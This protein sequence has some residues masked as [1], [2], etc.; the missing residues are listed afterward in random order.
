MI[1]V[2][3]ITG[4]TSQYSLRREYW[5]LLYF[6]GSE[7]PGKTLFF[8]GSISVQFC[9]KG[10]GHNIPVCCYR[11]SSVSSTGQAFDTTCDFA[12]SMRITSLLCHE[13]TPFDT[14]LATQ[15]RQDE[16]W[17]ASPPVFKLILRQHA[18][19]DSIGDRRDVNLGLPRTIRVEDQPLRIG[20]EIRMTVCVL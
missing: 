19:G 3:E 7:F 8:G 10:V 13:V 5:M 1:K 11:S 16:R 2:S 12:C 18:R 15:D 14:P 17:Y 9:H 4:V 6:C 20:R